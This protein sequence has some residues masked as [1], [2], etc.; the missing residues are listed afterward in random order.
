MRGRMEG[1]LSLGDPAPAPE[2]AGSGDEPYDDLPPLEGELASP[3]LQEVAEQ[4]SYGEIFLADLVRRQRRL[5]L[6]V[7]G[8]YLLF[9]C[10]LPL[11]NLLVPDL[12]GLAVLGLPLGWLV[13]A[14]AVYPLLWGLAYYFVT[15]ARHYEDEFTEL[16]R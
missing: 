16:V 5:S 15:T 6:S 3:A 7:A 10:A 9:L 14:V 8:V 1:R 2:R 4:T 13:L 12:A 11:V